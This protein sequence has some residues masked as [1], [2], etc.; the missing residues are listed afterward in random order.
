MVKPQ[1]NIMFAHF[2]MDAHHGITMDAHENS[3]K[4]HGCPV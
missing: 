2:T 3:V 1:Q 4:P